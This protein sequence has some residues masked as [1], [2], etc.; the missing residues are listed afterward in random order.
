MANL[1]GQRLGNRYLVQAEIGRGGMGVVY[2]ALDTS[3]L[4]RTVAIKMPLSGLLTEENFLERFIHEARQAASLHHPNIV[5]IYDIGEQD[6]VPFIVMQYLDG[7]TLE[8]ILHTRDRLSPEQTVP[9]LRQLADALDYVHGQRLVHRDIKTA[10]V[11]LS[12]DGKVTLTDFGLVRATESA[13]FTRSHQT[14]GTAEFMSPEQALGRSSDPRSDNYSLGIVAYKMLTGHV[15]FERETSV[16]TLVAHASEAPPSPRVFRSDLNR[17]L[18]AVLTKALAKN[19]DER[20]Q[21][22]GQFAADLATAA[23]GR[24]PAIP[25]TVTPTEKLS[26]LP[27]RAPSPKPLE[28]PSPKPGPAPTALLGR[29]FAGVTTTQMLGGAAAL[30][31]CVLLATLAWALNRT[32]DVS[33]TPVA[34]VIL[35]LTATPTVA[36]VASATPTF[37]PTI[38][39]AIPDVTPTP[40]SVTAGATATL[41]PPWTPTGQTPTPRPVATTVTLT[42]TRGSATQTPPAPLAP[43]PIAPQ[44]RATGLTG[45]VSFAWDYG[46]TLGPGQ[47]FEVRIWKEGQ[48]HLG[49]AAATTALELT[50]DLDVAPGILNNNK[51]EGEYLWAVAVIERATGAR[52]GRESEPRHFTYSPPPVC[53][54]GCDR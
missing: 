23:T 51:A 26:P 46:S 43:V 22:A 30:F 27:G 4:Q 53:V 35:N 33:P 49:A 34:T 16:A 7:Q 17:P 37:T 45:R 32:P 47:A 39:V 14:V 6:G 44:E 10:N 50:I 28:R 5:T 2:R 42:P 9:L 24:W 11:M 20:Y 19:P 38:T 25:R 13:G 31:I 52:I 40:A 18:E 3:S 1:V 41:A 8:K 15:P 29:V 12:A 21:Q 36:E 48:Q 54:G